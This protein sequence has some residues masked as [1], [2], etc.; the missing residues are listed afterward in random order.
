MGR[1]PDFVLDLTDV[2]REHVPCL[3][4]RLACNRRSFTTHRLVEGA[5]DEREPN[6]D[7]AC[8]PSRDLRHMLDLIPMNSAI[9]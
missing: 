5:A 4:V 8:S 2:H 6:A 9:P 3:S 1:N 7:G